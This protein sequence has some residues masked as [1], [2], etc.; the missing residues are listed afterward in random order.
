MGQVVA[1]AVRTLA[2]R[3]TYG[4]GGTNLPPEVVEAMR[5]SYVFP[6]DTD[7]VAVHE[8]VVSGLRCLFGTRGDVLTIMGPIR[9]AMD[10]TVC[11]LVERGQRVLLLKN[12]YWSGLFEEIVVAHGG[13]PVVAESVWGEPLTVDWVAEQLDR[14]QGPPTILFVTHVETST[15]VANPIADI[16][17]LTRHHRFC[18]VVDA[19]QSLGG[20]PVHADEWNAD[21]CIGGNHKCMSAPAGLAYLAISPQAWAMMER[22]R[23]PIS[24][25]Y[26]SLLVW[27]DMWLRRNRP[28][29]TYSASLVYG[30]QAA[31]KL[32]LAR[33][34]QD[35][36]RRYEDRSLALRCGLRAMELQ[37]VPP[38]ER[39]PGC[40]EGERFCADTVTAVRYPA[41]VAPAQF[42][43][44]LLKRYGVTVA[45]GLGS[46]VGK[47][48]RLGPTGLVQLQCAVILD[49]LCH[50]AEALIECGARLDLKRGMQVAAEILARDVGSCGVQGGS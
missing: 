4:P 35:L 16:A 39:C 21:V 25:W 17:S 24:G 19:A 45:G 2:E 14:W 11:S 29:Y 34:A 20:M 8:E 26:T 41:G 46:N 47:I 23:T 49:M 43:A 31:L 33:G 30:L 6:W 38:C 44:A 22:R 18:L 28:Y 37:M 9:A 12:G 40:Q 13:V 10:A 5:Q 42:D 50:V 3:I 15:G 48:F 27:R 1:N 36:Y 7:F 32:L